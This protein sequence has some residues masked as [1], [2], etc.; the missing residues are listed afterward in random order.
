[1]I[2]VTLT[3]DDAPATSYERRRETSRRRRRRLADA[4][5]CI[6]GPKHPGPIRGRRCWLCIEVHRGNR[7]YLLEF[8]PSKVPA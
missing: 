3:V 5:R 2:D 1:M 8:M 7:E 4:Q 6:N